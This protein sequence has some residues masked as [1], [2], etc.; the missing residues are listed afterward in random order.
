LE[1]LL[2]LD[3]ADNDVMQGIRSIYAGLS[4]HERRLSYLN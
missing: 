1:Y 4:G 2:A 3:S